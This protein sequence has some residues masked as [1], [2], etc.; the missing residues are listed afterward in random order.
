MLV[1]E[2]QNKI[3]LLALI[4]FNKVDELIKDGRATGD[5]SKYINEEIF[6][7]DKLPLGK[8]CFRVLDGHLPL[9]LHFTKNEVST[10]KSNPLF[11]HSESD[12][13]IRRS[14]QS[15]T[16]FG[17]EETELSTYQRARHIADVASADVMY[18]PANLD[19][20]IEDL[21]ERES[22]PSLSSVCSVIKKERDFLFK[23]AMSVR[24]HDGNLLKGL[25]QDGRISEENKLA[26]R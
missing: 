6:L 2:T 25:T 26:L 21:L 18:M 10:L 5:P 7:F 15:I 1:L 23:K 24:N 4:P 16:G 12:F 14:L 19:Q 3:E 22:S 20:A 13:L 11:C 8:D 9:S 17:F